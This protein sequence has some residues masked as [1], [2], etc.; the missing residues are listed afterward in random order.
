MFALA[1]Y[2]ARVRKEDYDLHVSTALD[3]VAWLVAWTSAGFIIYMGIVK[4]KDED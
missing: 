2:N 1:V 4:K 3:I